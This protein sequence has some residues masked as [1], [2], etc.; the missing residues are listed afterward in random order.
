M[1]VKAA[2][3]TLHAASGLHAGVTAAGHGRHDGGRHHHGIH[4]S[5]GNAPGKRLVSSATGLLRLPLAA[6]FTGKGRTLAPAI[7]L[8]AGAALKTIVKAGQSGLA[9]GTDASLAL[10]VPGLAADRRRD[11]TH[12]T[13]PESDTTPDDLEAAPDVT[14][15]A[16]TPHVL[17]AG[18][19]IALPPIASASASILV[20]LPRPGPAPAGMPPVPPPGLEPTGLII[21]NNGVV[22]TVTQLLGSTTDA[23]FQNTSG[24]VSNGSLHVNNANFTQGYS[25]LSALGVPLLNLTPVG[26]VLTT[27][28]DVVV[29]GTGINSHLTL[30]GGVTSGNY[31]RNI[32]NG[33]AGGLLGLVLPDEAPAWAAECVSV[34]GLVTMD[35]WAVNAAQDYQVL[36]GD[37]A[38]ANGSKEVVIGTGAHHTLPM[39]DADEA[40]PGDGRNDPDNPTGVPTADYAAR[41]GHS[42]VIGDDAGGTANAQTIVGAE[43]SASVANSVA[44]G[45][46][47][48]A[49]RGAQTG[50]AGFGMSTPQNSAGEVSV[51]AD[52]QER[53]ITHVA[54]GSEATDAANVAQLQAVAALADGAV[55]YDV[56]GAGDPTNQVT[57]IGD[58][59]G[60][61][62]GI[63]NLA[64]GAV[65]AGSLDAVNGGQ[66]AA[67]NAALV[68]YMGGSTAF[69]PASG[70]W[71][72]PVFPITSVAADGSTSTGD[73]DNVT[74][75]F[76]AVDG[77]LININNRVSTTDALAVKYDD[78]GAGSPTNTVTLTGDGTGAPV[79]MTNLAPGAVDAGSLDA[80]N[81]A[82]LFATNTAL[83]DFMGGSTAF[84]AA[85]GD[86]TGPIFPITSVATDGSTS[87]A[88]YDNVTDAFAAV[89][90]SLLNINNRT[91]AADLLAVK[92][93]A[94]ADGDPTNAI[95]LAGDGTGSPV[96]I[97]HVA[98][99]S[100]D[101]GSLEAINGAQLFA[102]N[103]AVVD[104]FGGSTAFNVSTGDW[105]GPVFPITS[106]EIDGSTSTSDYDNVTDAFEAVDGSLVNINDRTDVTDALAVKYDADGAGNATNTVTLTGDGSGA[107][108]TVTNLAPGS[109]DAGSLDAINGAQLFATNTAIVDYF[110]GTTAFNVSTGDWTGPVFPITSVEIN[111]DTST[112]DYDNVTDAFAAVDNS[113]V[114]LNTRI[115]NIDIDTIDAGDG[116]KYF[117][118]FSALG[119]S[120]AGGADSVAIGPLAS[121]VGEASMAM[122]RSASA[123]GE[124]ALA[125]GDGA[126]ADMDNSVALGA[127]SVTT[128]GA[129][130]GYSAYGL[131]APQ[132][133]T[134][135]VNVGQ[136]QITGVAAGA[137]DD[138]AVNVAQLRAVDTQIGAIDKLAVKYDADVD[139]NA[140]NSITLTGDGSGAPVI[141][142]QL[143]AGAES[144]SSTE[145]V[146]G[147]QLWHWT[148]DTT[149]IYSNR[150][151]YQDIQN[152]QPGSGQVKYFNVNST[153]ADSSATGS[154]AV[155]IGPEAEA[156]GDG[157]VALGNGASASAANAVALGA[158]SVADRADSVSVGSSGHERQ[159]TN[160]AAGTAAT[161]AVNVA[162]MESMVSDSQEGSV[163]YDRN[164]DGSIDYTNV[165]L[166]NGGGDTTIHNVAAGTADSDAVNVDQFKHGMQQAVDWANAYTDQRFGD[167][168]N[169]IDKMGREA[170]AGVAAAMAMAGL[171]QAYEPGKSMAAVAGSSFHGESSLAIG[172][173]AISEGGRWV[174]KLTGS[175]NSRGDTGV[176]IGA[177]IQW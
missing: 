87:S 143:A 31:I 22:G 108:V 50:Y 169:R 99:G 57:L 70:N 118:A 53:Q 81:G 10:A 56:D 150:S 41:Q 63:G 103:M 100:V 131:S 25:T 153:G 24:Y 136:R 110:G 75:A 105:T 80:I 46:R 92:Y 146:N 7:G 165:S 128:V 141:I 107:P 79:A 159:I 16:A 167:L 76:A 158:G 55:R 139:G 151:L 144:A 18:A 98:A 21:G 119:D 36:V 120:T 34:L 111:G 115:D 101:A 35:C 162:Q 155:A 96:M 73:Y 32:N 88:D 140:L 17:A 124:A 109:V 166:G 97:D 133:S 106:V 176:T 154:D 60:A 20:S 77:S 175:T 78:D 64:D 174:Y 1:K 90:N 122:G 61:P 49:D 65:V 171:P 170:N 94:D 40:F 19:S 45:Y 137:A 67:T 5:H 82:Q 102:T 113:V 93:D 138:D 42:V 13:G 134:G 12:S 62:V 74:D 148:E 147:S 52:G 15:S 161:D 125:L 85:S 33:A 68:D 172:V 66:L 91:S 127:G 116:I 114:N 135:E 28:D 72:G 86:W 129:L 27:V 164:K 14:P 84:D 23:L 9:A 44:L 8:D 26:S 48:S 126:T 51:G 69:D 132:D 157:S 168:D 89:D 123:V 38:S 117:H 47:S 83:V 71:T 43:A 112:S 11:H 4:G 6:T 30:V 3:G 121:A 156:A 149:N 59:T 29:G 177:G 54:A 58:G 104:Y 152:L 173:S 142:S 37:G 2:G 39:M 163:R 160:V 130:S 95:T 145:A